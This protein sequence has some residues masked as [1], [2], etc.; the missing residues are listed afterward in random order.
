MAKKPQKKVTYAIP[1]KAECNYEATVAWNEC[2][3]AWEKWLE[4]KDV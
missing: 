1:N 4:D 2:C 3:D